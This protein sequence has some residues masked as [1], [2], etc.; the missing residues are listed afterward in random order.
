MGYEESRDKDLEREM[1]H[2]RRIDRERS[3]KRVET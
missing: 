3:R 1:K 2:E